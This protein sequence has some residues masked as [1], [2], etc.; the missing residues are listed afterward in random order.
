MTHSTT[1]TDTSSL[2]SLYRALRLRC[3][4]CGEGKLFEQSF[5]MAK[6][7]YHCRLE[8]EPEPGFYLGS[9]Y[10]NYGMTV[11]LV[12]PVY[13]VLVLGRGFPRDYVI[14]PCVAFT[15]LFPLWF[16]R[17]ARSLWLSI[18]WRASSSDF[19]RRADHGSA[20]SSEPSQQSAGA[21]SNGSDSATRS[22]E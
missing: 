19:A 11:L 7:C 4:R 15:T 17:Y 6:Q 18:A 5:R 22:V 14:W 3:P 21:V 8:N 1:S 9:I 13:V 2:A 12:V 16:F 10:F 20:N